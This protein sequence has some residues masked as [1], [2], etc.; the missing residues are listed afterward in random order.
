MDGRT[1]WEWGF[2]LTGKCWCLHCGE[3]VSV[4]AVMDN[5]RGDW[6]PTPGCNGGG[7]AVD[8]WPGPLEVS[9]A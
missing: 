9:V 4:R 3:L 2:D 8:L 5:A 6:C 7:F 1:L